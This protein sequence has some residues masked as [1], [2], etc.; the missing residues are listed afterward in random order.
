MRPWPLFSQDLFSIRTINNGMNFSNIFNLLHDIKLFFANYLHNV[1]T[2][3]SCLASN[4]SYGPTEKY[5][6]ILMILSALSSI[7][8]FFIKRPMDYFSLSI[9]LMY[10]IALNSGLCFYTGSLNALNRLT[11]FCFPFI[12]LNLAS[13]LLNFNYLMPSSTVLS[14]YLKKYY[15]PIS[16]FL[17]FNFLF[18][19]Y[20]FTL[21]RQ[22]IAQ[23]SQDEI[24]REQLINNIHS[25]KSQLF[26]GPVDFCGGYIYKNY[27]A[28]FSF[29]PRDYDTLV[30]LNQK[31]PI[32]TIFFTKEVTTN[33]TENDFKKTGFVLS[34][35]F[36]LNGQEY[37]VYYKNRI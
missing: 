30:L 26:V 15:A 34:Q 10:L 33:L 5:F 6:F 9:V 3:K 36:I 35:K 24:K 2:L 18:A 27:P 4:S 7:F 8:R 12:A 14:I 19:I 17:T 21:L 13:V 23:F 28:K 25:D 31:Y 11:L 22:D 20:C 16:I 29:I 32:G 37:L 1:I